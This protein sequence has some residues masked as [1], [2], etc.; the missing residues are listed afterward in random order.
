MFTLTQRVRPY[1]EVVDTE[2]EG[3]GA[4]LLHLESQIYFSLNET[5]TLIWKAM[6]QGLTLQEFC[7]RLQKEFQVWTEQAEQS[8]LGLTR[9]LAEQKLVKIAEA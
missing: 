8:V 6:K 1:P 7:H 3:E 9:E 2:L 4:V 5:G